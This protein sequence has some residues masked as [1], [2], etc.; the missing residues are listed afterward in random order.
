MCACLFQEAGE[1]DSGKDSPEEAAA[2]FTCAMFETPQDVLKGTRHMVL[3]T[4]IHNSEYSETLF[5]LWSTHL[6]EILYPIVFFFLPGS[7]RDWL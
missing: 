3:I 2:N 7:S 1:L 4:H 5:E 6:N